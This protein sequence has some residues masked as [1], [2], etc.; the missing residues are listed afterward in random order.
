MFKTL[1]NKFDDIK[2]KFFSS[3]KISE[4]NIQEGIEEIEKALINADV[5][6]R[7]VKGLVKRVKEKAIGEE[8]IKSITPS[9]LFIKIV[10][11]EL[12]ELMKTDEQGL[13]ITKDFTIIMMVGLQGSG[14]TTT[15]GKLA[16]YL[17]K[18]GHRPFLVGADTQRPAAIEQLKVLGKALGEE[19]SQETGSE[20]EVPVYS[21][22]QDPPPKICKDSISLA[23][24][25]NC[26]VLIL[27]T[28][29]RLHIDDALMKE[30]LSIRKKTKPDHVFFVM[31]SMTGQNAFDSAKAFDEQINIDGVVLTKLDSDAKGGA[32]LSIKEVTGKSIKFIG[33]GEK[34]DA[35]EEFHADRMAS[36][37][38]GMGDVVS[39]V[40]KAEE[41]M[42]EEKA[43]EMY[44]KMVDASFTM[45]DLLEQFQMIK[46]M[47]NLRDLMGMLPGGLG[48]QMQNADIDESIFSR[49]EAIIHSMTPQERET[50]DMIN[51]SRKL[52]MSKG[53]GTK[54]QEVNQLLNQFREMRKMMQNMSKSGMFGN[55]MSGMGMGGGLGDLGNMMP[56]LGGGSKQRSRRKKKK[57]KKK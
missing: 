38:L 52:R 6:F 25:N 32:A 14:K 50:P 22:P 57:R 33:V 35:L 44:Q 20:F 54:V 51:G 2:N 47:G 34:L 40:K 8:L 36:R 18:K 5:N 1:S 3:G 10:N 55:M 56:G 17:I 45:H 46:K 37:I 9:Q 49:I 24:E 16:R 28:A 43:E 39:L 41:V 12:V 48:V 31:D 29:G 7:V 30:L 53:S 23:K 15:C 13:E 27:D 42:D 21:E 4:K 11:D 19:I 26:D